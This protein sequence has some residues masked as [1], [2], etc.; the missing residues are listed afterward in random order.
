MDRRSYDTVDLPELRDELILDQRPEYWSL[1]CKSQKL[2]DETQPQAITDDAL[3]D[4]NVEPLLLHL[5]IL[6]D[7]C[8]PRWKEAAANRNLVYNDILGKIHQRNCKETKPGHNLTRNAFF[9]L[10][11]CLGLAA[12]RGNLRIGTESA[13]I[14]IRDIHAR[15]LKKLVC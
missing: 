15:V 10:M 13:F 11:E 7:Y 1:W 9:L 2:T 3:F 6:S 14:E 12:W 5:L 4:L 8:G